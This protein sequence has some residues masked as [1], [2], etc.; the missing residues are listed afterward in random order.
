M[1]RAGY[2]LT[3]QDEFAILRVGERYEAGFQDLG[4]EYWYVRG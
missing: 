1:A 4:V 2:D 3:P